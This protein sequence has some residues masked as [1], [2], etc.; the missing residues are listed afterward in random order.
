MAVD[1]N[2]ILAT[3]RVCPHCGGDPQIMQGH[4]NN[5]LRFLSEPVIRARCCGYGIKLV[6]VVKVYAVAMPKTTTC[7]SMGEPLEFK[8]GG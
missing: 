1:T 5:C 4:L 6:P 2:A 3:L 8:K 7:G